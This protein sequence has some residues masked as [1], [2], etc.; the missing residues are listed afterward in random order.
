MMAFSAELSLE[1]PNAWPCSFFAWLL[2]DSTV[3]RELAEELV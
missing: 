2:E 3:G 1:R